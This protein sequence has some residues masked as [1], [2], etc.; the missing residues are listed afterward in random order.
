MPAKDIHHGAVIEA[1]KKVGWKITHDPLR[2][3]W[4]GKV[5]FVDLGA[6]PIIAAEKAQEKIAVEIKTFVNPHAINDIHSAAGQYIFYRSVLR[7]VQPERE[8]YLAIPLNAFDSLFDEGRVGE[9]LLRDEQIHVI[10]FE[11]V[12]K[13]I[14]RW[15]EQ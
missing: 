13:E 7:R 12:K 10:V 14:V 4:Q 2:V 15:L 8:L 6:E 1:L 3:L 5:M 9:V 11:P